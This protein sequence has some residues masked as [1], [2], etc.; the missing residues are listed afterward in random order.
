[1]RPARDPVLPRAPCVQRSGCALGPTPALLSVPALTLRLGTRVQPPGG[2]MGHGRQ[3]ETVRGTLGWTV[4]IAVA[5]VIPALTSCSSEPDPPAWRDQDDFAGVKAIAVGDDGTVYVGGNF[6]RLGSQ[7]GGAVR[8]DGMT[9][10]PRGPFPLLDGKVLAAIPDDAG[11]WYIGG[12]FTRAK[13]QP[14]VNL[15]HVLADGSLDP[16]WAPS[17]TFDGTSPGLGVAA[18]ARA[19]DVIYVGGSFTHLSGL[20]RQGLGAV[21]TTGKVT[22]W[23]PVLSSG[24]V[25]SMGIREGT[26]YLGGNFREVNGEPRMSLA[27]VD[28]SGALTGWNP[29]AN[30]AY[31][32]TNAIVY[33]LTIVGDTVVVG[34]EF[35]GVGGQ[36]R[37]AL[38]ALDPISGAPTSW[39]PHLEYPTDSSGP[40]VVSVSVRNGT[41][42]AAG[43]FTGV[44][45]QPRQGVAAFDSAGALLPWAPAL[46]A[47]FVSRVSAA[48][49]SI[50]VAGPFLEAEG[51]KRRHLA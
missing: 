40:A 50:Y 12:D 14:R 27:A 32:Y 45:G 20:A 37:T 17:A 25:L 49:G 47:G 23:A 6:T 24:G 43:G 13:G 34:G 21:D 2:L 4:A 44:N 19:G 31:N 30:T 16:A 11:G 8:V 33:S 7:A 10:Q 5:L 29:G 39:A 9:G 26:V 41:V 42:Y 51:R 36:P 28:S 18:L 3:E 15:A 35:A 1:M 38:A 48:A 22:D 46:G